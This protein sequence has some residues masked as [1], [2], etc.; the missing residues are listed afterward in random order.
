M[1]DRQQ[2]VVSEPSLNARA[3]GR[4]FEEM[5]STLDQPAAAARPV[6]QTAGN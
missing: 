5:E 4:T 1:R 2:W 6:A 3:K